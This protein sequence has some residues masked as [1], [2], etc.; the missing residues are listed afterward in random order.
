MSRKSLSKPKKLN[1]S[2]AP[3]KG[4]REVKN[5][6]IHKNQAL[7]KKILHEWHLYTLKAFK[8]RMVRKMKKVNQEKTKN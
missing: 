3:S 4:D 8:E 6:L 2:H 1:K 7:L 5:I